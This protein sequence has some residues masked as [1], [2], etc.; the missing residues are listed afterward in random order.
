MANKITRENLLEW[1]ENPVTEQLKELVD[2]Y[3]EDLGA[4]RGADC[5][6]FGEPNR[7][8]DALS[9]LVGEMTAWGHVAEALEGDWSIFS[10]GED[11]EYIRYLSEGE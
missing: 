3:T 1:L 8:Q 7:T 4:A 11:D 2:S 6:A 10:K 5:Y 9:Q